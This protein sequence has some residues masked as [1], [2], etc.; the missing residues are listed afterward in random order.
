MWLPLDEPDGRSLHTDEIRRMLEI[1]R[2]EKMLCT[3]CGHRGANVRP[4][5]SPHVNK[6][7]V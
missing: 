5:W 2:L 7:Q 4:D 1:L 6:R 3:K